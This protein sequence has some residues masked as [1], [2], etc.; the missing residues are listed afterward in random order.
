MSCKHKNGSASDSKHVAYDMR[1]TWPD[2]DHFE[3]ENV[4]DYFAPTDKQ[5]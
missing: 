5:N 2:S 1:N 4:S 3:G